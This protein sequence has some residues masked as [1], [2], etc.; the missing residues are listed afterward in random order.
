MV[1]PDIKNDPN[2]EGKGT[3]MFEKNMS[4]TTNKVTRQCV[5]RDFLKKYLSY[6]KSQKAPELDGDCVEYAA[7]C[8]AIIRQKAAVYD[9][10]Q[11][12]CP[13]TVR[14]LETLIR[15]ATAHSKLRMS[16]NVETND[17]DVAINFVHMSI[18]GKAM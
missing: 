8:Y 7:Q 15:L 11:I 3:T 17:I 5:T 6:V 18:F 4:K 13:V 10:T 1:E 16:K 14:T 9:Q 12:A 2:N